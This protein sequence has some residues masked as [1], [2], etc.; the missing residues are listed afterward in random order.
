MAQSVLSLPRRRPPAFLRVLP[1]GK[2]LAI[3]AICVTCAGGIYA[4]ARETSMFAISRIEVRGAPPAVSRN[5]SGALRPFVGNS[6]VS[7]DGAAVVNRLE[8]LPTVVSAKYDRDFPHTLRVHV[9]PERAVAVLRSGAISWLVSARGR[10][11][12]TV[13]RKRFRTLPRIWL[14][15]QTR[16]DVGSFLSDDAG[17]AAR[18]LRAFAATGFARRA[19]WARIHDAQ[20]TVGLRSG[21]ELRFGAPT[22]LALKIAVVRSILPTV[23]VPAAGGPSYLDVSVPERPVAGTNSQPEG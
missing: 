8:A 6:L 23:P 13:D 2:A 4:L 15:P 3:A 5:I 12:A 21:V 10:A 1:S 7:L 22:D 14:P 18:A 11:M 16:V 19:I 20:L 17:T 9:V